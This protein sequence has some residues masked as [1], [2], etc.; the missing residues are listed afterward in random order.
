M[1]N[2]NVSPVHCGSCGAGGETDDHKHDKKDHKKDDK[3]DDK[4]DEKKGDK[5]K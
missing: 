5:P 2:E 3:K 4:K 1:S